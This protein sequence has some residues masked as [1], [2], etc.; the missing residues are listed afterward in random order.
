[1][2]ETLGK[3]GVALSKAQG[4]MKGAAKDSTNPH[5]KSKYAGL[6]SIWDACREQLHKNEIAVVQSPEIAEGRMV[7]RTMLIHSSGETIEGFLPIQVAANATSQQ[8]GSA[9]TYA[10]RYSLASMVGVAP[11]EDD[12]DGNAAS[13]TRGENVPSGNYGRVRTSKL[14][15]NPPIITPLNEPQA[16]PV[17]L[18]DN[19]SDWFA[20]AETLAAAIKVAP[21]P[22]VVNEW[23]LRNAIPMSNM[24]KE[25]QNKKPNIHAKLLKTIE[26]KR[27]GFL[28]QPNMDAG[29]VLQD[30]IHGFAG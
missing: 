4:E 20:W 1:M 16:I 30:T 29:A 23:T 2:T 17:P 27:M 22:E 21:T 10:R 18:G 11:A 14:P 8:V 24:A 3:I 12:D 19:G 26:M 15:V 25:F 6:S 5:F 28:G 9:I 13:E 7:L